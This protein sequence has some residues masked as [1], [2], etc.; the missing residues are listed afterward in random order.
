MTRRKIGA[1][2]RIRGVLDIKRTDPLTPVRGSVPSH[3]TSEASLTRTSDILGLT[4]A[5]VWRRTSTLTSSAARRIPQKVEPRNWNGAPGVKASSVPPMPCTGWARNPEQGSARRIS[6]LDTRLTACVA[7][8]YTRSRSDGS[9]RAPPWAHPGH[10]PAHLGSGGTTR[11]ASHS[12]LKVQKTKPQN[13]ELTG[14]L[15][16]LKM[17]V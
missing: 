11:S 4:A 5:L 13:Q 3:L 12:P 16:A 9:A 2:Q 6:R 1:I 8:T 17:T 15:R 14:P 10:S 7:V